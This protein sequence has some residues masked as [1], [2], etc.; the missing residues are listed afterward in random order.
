MI[1]YSPINDASTASHAEFRDDAANTTADDNN[2]HN[3]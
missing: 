3:D 2:N 1:S